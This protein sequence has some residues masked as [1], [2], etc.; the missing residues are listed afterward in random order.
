MHPLAPRDL[1]QRHPFAGMI[2][3]VAHQIGQ[4]ARHL[5]ICRKVPHH[6]PFSSICL[7]AGLRPAVVYLCATLS[8]IGYALVKISRFRH[9]CFQMLNIG[10]ASAR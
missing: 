1:A 8:C 2:E 10:E 7:F 3:I 9:D 6:H 5:H 4:P